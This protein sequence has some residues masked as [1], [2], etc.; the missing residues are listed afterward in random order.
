[1]KNR[2]DGESMKYT[3]GPTAEA[4]VHID[5]SPDQVWP[6]VSDIHL[7]AELSVEVQE[8]AGPDGVERAAV[9]ATFRGR[10]RHPAVGEWTTVSHVVECAARRAP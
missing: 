8:V 7:I 9:G 10:N 3:D 2:V 4:T 6:L 5:A 1:M